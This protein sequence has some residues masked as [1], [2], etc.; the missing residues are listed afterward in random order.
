MS[1]VN[2]FDLK[3]AR[4][5]TT[6]FF[7]I[8]ENTTGWYVSDR[9][10]GDEG[11]NYLTFTPDKDKADKFSNHRVDQRV[12]ADIVKSDFDL[13]VIKIS[14]TNIEIDNEEEVN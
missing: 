11:L 13:K 4:T 5:K 2:D 6:E 12:L 1:K 7:I 10:F 3:N 8:K 9:N 14:R